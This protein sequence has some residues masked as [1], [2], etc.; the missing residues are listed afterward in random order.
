MTTLANHYVQW[1][2]ASYEE[3]E[4]ED[5]EHEDVE[6]ATMVMTTIRRR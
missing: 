1:G 2:H 4:E 5:D 6:C 3:P